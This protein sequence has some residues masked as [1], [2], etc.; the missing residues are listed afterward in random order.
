[1]PQFID[2]DFVVVRREPKSSAKRSVTLAF[3]DPVDVLGYD[4][5]W[6]RIRVLSYFSGPFVG[7]VRGRLPVR[8]TGIVKLSMVDVQ[9][10]DGLILETP[11]GQIVFIDGGDNKLFARH[12]AARFRHRQTSADHPL[13]VAAILI[14][15]GDA[16]HFDGLNDIRRSETLPKRDARKRVFIHPRRVFHNGLVKRPSE[17][18]SGKDVPDRLLF[19]RSDEQNGQLLALDLYDDPRDAPAV[20][21]PFGWWLE[22]LDH[23][24]TRG[25]IDVR[26]VAYGMDEDDLFGFLHDEGL[27]VEVQG[28]FATTAADPD[29]GQARPALRFFRQP[30]RSAE[31]HLEDGEAGGSY[32]ASHTINGHSIALRLTYGNVRFSLTGDLNREA[33]AQML[34]NVP[35]ENLEAEIVKAPHHGSHDFSYAALRAMRPVVAIVSSGDENAFKEHIHPRAT[36]MAALGGAMRGD[37][38]VIFSTELAAFFETRDYCHTR[39]ELAA[40]FRERKDETFTG[41]QLRKMFTGR[42]KK[43][44]APPDFY[45]FERTNFG[46]VHIRTDGERVLA[47]T[48]S[49]KKGLNEAY[50]FRVEMHG[51]QRTVTFENL[52]TR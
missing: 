26:R 4:G 17:D 37:T 39:K 50:R 40:F 14:T 3:G 33:M 5:G 23:W 35:P 15:H 10:G 46:I 1:M 9:Q 34:A 19:G 51:A 45:G 12:V 18:A 7:F 30:A 41:E 21:R 36:L 52:E 11:G 16:D 6:T 25:P 2:A 38:G 24:Q 13:E 29:T 32:S 28:P 48:H 43:G 42:T 8:D 22:S 20:N 27:R 44:E 49:G 47:F 31:L